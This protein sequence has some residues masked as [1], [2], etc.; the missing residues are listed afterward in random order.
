MVSHLIKVID[1]EYNILSL[2]HT[3]YC[4]IWSYLSQMGN[5]NKIFE[6]GLSVEGKNLDLIDFET[7]GGWR[8]DFRAEIWTCRGR[9]D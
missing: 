7:E 1:W 3:H 5:H 9:F 8:E 2:S 6:D 4:N